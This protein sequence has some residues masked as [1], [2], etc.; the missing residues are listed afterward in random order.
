MV[1]KVKLSDLVAEIIHAEKAAMKIINDN[2][3]E[4]TNRKSIT[5]K[6]I[7]YFTDKAKHYYRKA[8]EYG[9]G[10]IVTVTFTYSST[11]DHSVIVNKG[12]ATYISVTDEEVVILLD[13][14]ASKN[15]NHIIEILEIKRAFTSVTRLGL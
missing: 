1:N 9:K 4:A 12:M 14:W 13:M 2:P 11:E 10:E 15:S 5:Y 8:I 3:H 7:A 6:R